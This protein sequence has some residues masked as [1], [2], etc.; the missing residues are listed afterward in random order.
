MSGNDKKTASYRG[1]LLFIVLLV[2]IG[3]LLHLLAPILTPFLV[4]ALLAYLADPSVRQLM[5]LR[6]PRIVSIILVFTILISLIVLFFLFLIPLLTDQIN[7]LVQ[8]IPN[9]AAWIQNN[10]VPW[11]VTHF[12]AVH[13]FNLNEFKT[14]FTDVLAKGGLLSKA[15]GVLTWTWTAILKSSAALMSWF[16]NII[17]VPVVTFYLLLDW[18][19]LVKGLRDLLPRKVEPVVVKLVKESDEVLSA[20]FRGQ[21]LVMLCLGIAYAVGLSLVGLK[22]GIMIGV[23]AGLLSIVPYLGFI[24]GVT[25]ASIAA[26][27]QFGDMKAILPVLLVFILANLFDAFFLTPNL[28]GDRIGLHPVAVI[29]A[30]LAGGSL[31]GFFGVLLALPVAAVTMVWLRY[32]HERYQHSKIYQ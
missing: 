18:D 11:F 27:V 13:T 15:G 1:A 24:A 9:I 26:V 14:D 5:R 31:F 3:F 21:L 30:V 32:L 8:E 16:L 29:F 17:L 7:D 22:L 6:I 23:F 2:A 4:G 25:A 19:R 20:F 28:V 10:V 12:N